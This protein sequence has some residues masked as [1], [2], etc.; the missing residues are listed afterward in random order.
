LYWLFRISAFSLLSITCSPFSFW[1]GDIPTESFFLD[2][3]YFQN[4]FP[5][6]GWLLPSFSSFRICQM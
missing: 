1:S 3:M 2:L 6:V 4:F 5:R